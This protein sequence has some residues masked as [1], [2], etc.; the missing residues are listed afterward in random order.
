MM[1]MQ[2]L[3]NGDID[4]TNTNIEANQPKKHDRKRL[5]K[6]LSREDPV[7][8]MTHMN[9]DADAA[10]SAA[11][12]HTLRPHATIV[13]A[14]ADHS[15]QDGGTIAI[16][17]S[18]GPRAVKGLE[19]GSAFGLIV[20]VLKDIDNGVH[21]ALKK[22]A[23]Q[24]DLTDSAKACND[25]VVLADMVRSWSLAGLDDYSIVERAGEL[26][27]GTIRGCKKSKESFERAKNVPIQNGIAIL[28]PGMNTSAK[29]LFRLGALAVVRESKIGMAINLSPR[30]QRV[31]LHLGELS[32][33]L[34]P[35]WFIHECG[36]LACYG[37]NKAPKNPAN[38]GL[39]L[40][41]LVKVVQNWLVGH[42]KS[43]QLKIK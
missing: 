42:E 18:N 29:N 22:W 43:G 28:K 30:A 3:E 40:A 17:M 8:I 23:A 9:V 32:G 10:F 38:S 34:P 41:E 20:N 39:K 37:S 36:F 15:P 1:T 14:P 25:R 13:F 35:N 31:G 6:W 33:N 27:L 7:V 19:Q 12:L 16:D 24:L 2:N 21:H 4:Q 11:L 26:L 5:R